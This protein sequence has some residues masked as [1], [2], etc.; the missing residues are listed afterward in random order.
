VFR[1]PKR[2]HDTRCFEALL[3]LCL[4]VLLCLLPAVLLVR[5]I[6]VDAV[7]LGHSSSTKAAAAAAITPARGAS[8]GSIQQLKQQ[9][10]THTGGHTTSATCSG[11]SSR[12]RSG[13]DETCDLIA[14][15]VSRLVELDVS[16]AVQLSAGCLLRLLD[17][18]GN[19]KRLGASGCTTLAA[20]GV[21]VFCQCCACHALPVLWISAT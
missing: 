7:F 2:G 20:A 10:S 12:R 13:G 8:K 9:Q 1:V 5:R 15:A 16:D 21:F 3:L 14:A 19:L 18:G 6:N 11:S 4:H 17:W